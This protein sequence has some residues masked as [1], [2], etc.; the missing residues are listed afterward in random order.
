LI[1][2]W[3]AAWNAPRRFVESVLEQG[4]SRLARVV[5]QLCFGY[6][7]N[8]WF[9]HGWWRSLRPLQQLRIKDFVKFMSSAPLPLVASQFVHW[10]LIETV[11]TEEGGE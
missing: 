8:T 1:F 2:G 7:E 4:P 11:Y 6:L 3:L 10:E 5:P 9:S